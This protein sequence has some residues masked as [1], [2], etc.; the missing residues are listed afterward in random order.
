MKNITLFV[1]AL[2]LVSCSRDVELSFPEVPSEIVVDGRIE[3]GQPPLIFLTRTQSFNAPLDPTSL[4]GL[5]LNDAIISVSNGTDTVQLVE[6]CAATLSDE[7]VILAAELLGISPE[8]LSQINYCVYTDLTLTMLGEEGVSYDL[9]I[10]TADEEKLSASTYIPTA[11]PLDSLWF[12]LWAGSD[13]LGF[14]H[15]ELSDPL[16]MRNA[17]RWWA[18]RTN[19]YP[20]TD[21]Q[22][23]FS[24]IAPVGSVFEDTFFDGLTF[25]IFYNR[26][27]T[28]NSN[29]PD[30][31]NE[32][33]G[34]YK[35]HDTVSVKFAATTLEVEAYIA[36]SDDQL[37]STGS[38]FAIPTNLPS[39]IIGGRGLW[40]G[41]AGLFY[42]VICEP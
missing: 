6:I 33:A 8:E 30:D 14:L 18:Q 29:K 11:V 41:Y 19:V 3:T 39:N 40:A 23:D 38:P 34:F 5:F 2:F 36:V 22:K 16:D 35:I 28:V 42:E 21:E 25:E 24:Y 26:G 9:S 32:E 7:E 10:I 27:T 13:S 15:A 20:G 1:L 31:N 17:Y 37:V 12:E 4:D